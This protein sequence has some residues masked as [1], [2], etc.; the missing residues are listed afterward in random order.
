LSLA[1]TQDS[2]SENPSKSVPEIE[3]AR[4]SRLPRVRLPR[5]HGR[6]AE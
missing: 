5:P 2:Q 4:R 6:P 3:L 1:I